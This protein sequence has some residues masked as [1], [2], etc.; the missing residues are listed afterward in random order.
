MRFA[1]DKLY[2]RPTV[3]RVRF[4]GRGGALAEGGELQVTDLA[5]N[6]HARNMYA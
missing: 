2:L 6:I 1:L 3:V 5:K 4:P